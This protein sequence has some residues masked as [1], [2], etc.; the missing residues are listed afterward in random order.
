VG[1]DWE[2]AFR[3]HAGT[4]FV[5]AAAALAGVLKRTLLRFARRLANM[6]CMEEGRLYRIGG[7]AHA[8]GVTFQSDRARV[9]ATDHGRD[10]VKRFSA[11]SR[12]LKAALGKIPLLRV[13]SAFG[14]AGAVIFCVLAALILAEALAPQLLCFEWALPD[15]AFLLLLS[16]A[17]IALLLAAALLRGPVRRTL[18]YHGAEHMAINAYQKG[19]E[20]TAEN[21]ARADRANA[22]CGSLFSLFLLIVGLPLIFVP[23]GDYLLP[24]ALCAAFELTVLARRVKWLRALLRFGLWTQRKIWTRPPD[25]AQIALARRG[26]VLLL[27][28]TGE[29]NKKGGA[30]S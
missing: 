5:Y 17:A 30:P 4:L 22:R 23:Y 10:R 27:E 7:R 20:L 3:Q 28:I 2:K 24:V 8:H 9:T 15:G 6:E 18:Q 12:R 21:I 26:L 29:E 16:A 25:E 13:F 14:K 1:G 19:L 11:R